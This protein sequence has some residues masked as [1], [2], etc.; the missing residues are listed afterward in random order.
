M[1]PAPESWSKYTTIVNAYV[2]M[3]TYRK[4]ISMTTV[5]KEGRLNVLTTV[6]V[7]PPPKKKKLSGIIMSPAKPQLNLL[8]TLFTV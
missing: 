4:S 7:D 3:R 8:T 1:L 6:D 2:C 5:K